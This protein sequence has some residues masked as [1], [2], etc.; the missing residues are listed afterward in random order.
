MMPLKELYTQFETL[1]M[2]LEGEETGEERKHFGILQCEV[3]NVEAEDMEYE[4]IFMLDRSSSMNQ[5]CMDGKTK[6]QH[7]IH[8]MKNILGYLCD[9]PTVRHHL[10]VETFNDVVTRVVDRCVVTAETYPELLRILDKIIP[11]GSTNIEEALA[12]IQRSTTT[13]ATAGPVNRKIVHLFMTDG[14]A[15]VGESNH[16]RLFEQV[17]TG[18]TNIFIGLGVDHDNV[19]LEKLSDVKQGSYYFIDALEKNNLVYGE[20]M[21]ELLF[22]CLQ[23]VRFQVTGGEIYDYTKN[24]WLDTL[25][26]DHL[27]SGANKTF[28][29]RSSSPADCRVV[30]MA[31]TLSGKPCIAMLLSKHPLVEAGSLTKFMFRQRTLEYM[32]DVRMYFRRA[33]GHHILENAVLKNRLKDK[34]QTF[35]AEMKQYR[36]DHDLLEDPFYALLE[37]DISVI[38]KT[39]DTIYASMYSCARQ[40]SQGSQRGYSAGVSLPLTQVANFTSPYLSQAVT[41]FTQKMDNN[42]INK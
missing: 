3:D 17:T 16:D 36:T 21:H 2:M 19:L 5:R 26:L 22:Q 9:H 27:S 29:L 33:K 37:E 12:S 7:V 13:L 38:L 11:N 42:R 15:T 1:P 28:H 10:V 35:L 6:L 20:I 25:S 34:L 18:I 39:F 30:L 14:Y 32:F 41:Q 24:Q 23:N 4:F 31:E 8:T 40:T